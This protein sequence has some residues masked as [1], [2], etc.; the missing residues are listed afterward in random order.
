[1]KIDTKIIRKV[2][3]RVD[4]TAKKDPEFLESVNMMV[5]LM[6]QE[7]LKQNNKR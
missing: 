5:M 2:L 7:Q 6:E 3:Y 1:M 4:N